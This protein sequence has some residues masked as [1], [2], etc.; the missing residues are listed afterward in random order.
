M[1]KSNPKLLFIEQ[2][3][4]DSNILYQIFFLLIDREQ[5]TKTTVKMSCLRLPCNQV[6]KVL[7]TLASELHGHLDNWT[8]TLMNSTVY[9]SRKKTQKITSKKICEKISLHPEPDIEPHVSADSNP[10]H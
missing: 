4:L 9:Q 10:V 2:L 6:I 1:W 8:E 5:K 7:R 3:L